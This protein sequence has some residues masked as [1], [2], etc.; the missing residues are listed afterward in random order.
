MLIPLAAAY[1]HSRQKSVAS[2][3][4]MENPSYSG[5]DPLPANKTELEGLRNFHVSQLQ[6]LANRVGVFNEYIGLD[7]VVL[8]NYQQDDKSK[9]VATMMQWRIKLQSRCKQDLATSVT[10]HREE[11]KKVLIR[12]MSGKTGETKK[13]DGEDLLSTYVLPAND[14]WHPN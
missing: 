8:S 10:Y 4:T 5:P 2:A 6:I 3:P 1:S 14:C 11:L 9:M 12:S 7:N 13:L